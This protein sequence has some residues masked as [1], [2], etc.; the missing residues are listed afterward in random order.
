LASGNVSRKKIYLGP[1]APQ[2][3]LLEENITDE[4]NNRDTNDG[5]SNMDMESSHPPLPPPQSAALVSQQSPN[6]PLSS[7]SDILST[8][9]PSSSVSSGWTMQS[10]PPELYAQIEHMVQQRVQAALPSTQ[11]PTSAAVCDVK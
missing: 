9:H 4:E 11:N 10:I 5:A 3:F 7:A 2:S 6:T 1:I 8:V